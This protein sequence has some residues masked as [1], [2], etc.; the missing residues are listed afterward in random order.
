M[1]DRLR[2]PVLYVPGNPGDQV[3]GMEMAVKDGIPVYI[4]PEN[5]IRCLGAM[6]RRKEFLER[7]QGPSSGKF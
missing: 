3:L 6:V 2:K 7:L 1:R 4:M 5:A